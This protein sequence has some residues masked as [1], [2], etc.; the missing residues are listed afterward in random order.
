MHEDLNTIRLNGN[1]IKVNLN[2]FQ[3]IVLGPP[4]VLS[5]AVSQN[6][7]LYLYWMPQ[8]NEVIGGG[9]VSIDSFPGQK[10]INPEEYA[11]L[12]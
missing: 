4:E 2:I 1:D 9:G 6:V 5:V 3:M 10:C 12:Q 8:H 7:S 11:R